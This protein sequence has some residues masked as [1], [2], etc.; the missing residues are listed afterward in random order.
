MLYTSLDS[1]IGELSG[2]R[3]AGP[4]WPLHAGGTHREPACGPVGAEDGPFEAV[5]AQLDEYWDGKRRDF[6]VPLA[7]HGSRSSSR[8]GGRCSR[9]R[10]ERRQLR[11]QAPGGAR[12]PTRVPWVRPTGAT[13]SP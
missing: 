6:D 11:E 8:H 4:P 3:R 10:M 12:P 13:R 1:P 7:L 2:R 5:R 9:S